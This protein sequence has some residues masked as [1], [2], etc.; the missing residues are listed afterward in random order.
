MSRFTLT[1]KRDAS[2]ETETYVFD[3]FSYRY[4]ITFGV[5]T[6]RNNN[7]KKKKRHF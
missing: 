1:S 7:K 2:I 6:P 4:T 3:L 5:P